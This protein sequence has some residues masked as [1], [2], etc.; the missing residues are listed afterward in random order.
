MFFGL[1]RGDLGGILEALGG[2]LEGLRGALERLGGVLKAKMSQDSAKMRQEP[3]QE[4]NPRELL[5]GLRP[6]GRWKC[7][8]TRGV[9]SGG[10][11]WSNPSFGRIFEE[12]STFTLS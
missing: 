11:A 12:E 4:R 9:G 2:V 1:P 8:L 5:S 10:G 6:Q 3:P 7:A